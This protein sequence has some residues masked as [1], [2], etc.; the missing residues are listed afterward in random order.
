MR[1]S[2]SYQR[3]GKKNGKN[4]SLAVIFQKKKSTLV[5]FLAQLGC[6]FAAEIKNDIDYTKGGG[7]NVRMHC[8]YVGHVHG[9]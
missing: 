6:I 7:E 9:D 3:Y 2:I 1:I 8:I 5:L 4:S